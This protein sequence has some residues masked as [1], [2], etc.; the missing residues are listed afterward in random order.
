L[1]LLDTDV[2]IEI[3]DRKSA[4]GEKILRRVLSQKESVGTTAINLH[5]ILYGLHRFAKPVG[6]VLLLPVLGYSK[7]D[8]VLSSK[9]E[10]DAEQHGISVRRADAMI[11]AISVNNAATLCTFD[12][13]HF[14]PMT[15]LGLKLFT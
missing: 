9:L 4:K 11:A 3:L 6:E 13:K 5:E 7:Q 8:A 2:L 14:R 12:T 10:L 15:S 1:I